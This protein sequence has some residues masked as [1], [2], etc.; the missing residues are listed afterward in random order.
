MSKLENHPGLKR[1]RARSCCCNADT[2][3]DNH[4]TS[5]VYTLCP[6][7]DKNLNSQPNIFLNCGLMKGPLIAIPSRLEGT[8]RKHWAWACCASESAVLI[9]TDR[10][11]L[12]APASLAQLLLCQR[13]GAGGS[14]PSISRA[15]STK[16]IL[17][18]QLL[19][20]FSLRFLSAFATKL[21][22]NQ[23]S[24]FL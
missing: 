24:L 18:K 13:W 3:H 8:W 4:C 15:G 11:I 20:L 14:S 21:K 17:Q 6:R 7:S 16:G 10:P 9:L 2:R 1:T 23:L 12:A 22:Q 19:H 5:L